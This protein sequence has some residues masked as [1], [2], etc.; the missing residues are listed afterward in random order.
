M[1]R[2]KKLTNIRAG[3]GV[4]EMAD[5]YVSER[6]VNIKDLEKIIS[7]A[8]YVTASL[9]HNAEK[10]TLE[11]EDMKKGL[12]KLDV[13]LHEAEEFDFCVERRTTRSV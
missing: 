11:K 12:S 4:I 5:M 10:N 1:L 9:L 6:V 7:E 2:S 8:R 3:G 13:L